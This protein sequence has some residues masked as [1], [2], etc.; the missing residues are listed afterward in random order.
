M[1]LGV[2]VR[3]I[4]IISDSRA[5]G[6]IGGIRREVETSFVDVRVGDYVILHAGFAIQ[7]LDQAE[8]EE[9]LQ[10]FKRMDDGLHS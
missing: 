1:C 9:T 8:A 4:E 3:I 10:L 2:P 5:I 7:K 6:E